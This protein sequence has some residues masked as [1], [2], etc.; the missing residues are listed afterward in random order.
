[1]RKNK[2]IS[3]VLIIKQANQTNEVQLAIANLHPKASNQTSTGEL[4][5]GHNLCDHA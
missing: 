1:M 5:E 4:I 3:E 2:Q